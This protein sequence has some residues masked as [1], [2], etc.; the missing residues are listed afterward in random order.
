MSSQTSIC[1]RDLL[2]GEA[3][4]AKETAIRFVVNSTLGLGGILDVASRNGL[5]FHREDFGQTL[6]VYGAGEGPF[7]MLPILGPSSPRDA[8]GLAVDI[9]A[10]S[11]FGY[12]HIKQYLWWEL[13]RN[14]MKLLDLRSRNIETLDSLERS[15][16]DYY[17][18][19]RSLYRQM[20]NAEIR[21]GKPDEDLP[22]Y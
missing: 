19:V 22:D 13:G 4:R 7:L 6:A 11:P 15:S 2:Q 3:K 16:I 8:T 1:R 18:S 5:P 9:F 21:N 20:R 10:L 14:Y 12:I 17:G